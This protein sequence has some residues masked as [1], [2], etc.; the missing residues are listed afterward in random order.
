MNFWVSAVHDQLLFL[1]YLLLFLFTFLKYYQTTILWLLLKKIHSSSL[2]TST[3][4]KG[5]E[6]TK[7]Q[8]GE[9]AELSEV[10]ACND[11]YSSAELRN[12]CE[13][14][15]PDALEIHVSDFVH[16]FRFIKGNVDICT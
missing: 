8:L 4:F 15:I 12:N 11:D 14:V 9:V 13:R 10:I 1:T 2:N 16:A 6:V 3:Y 5:Y 7:E